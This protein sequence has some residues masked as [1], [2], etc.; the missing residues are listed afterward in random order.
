[1]SWNFRQ[2]LIQKVSSAMKLVIH[3]TVLLSLI[4]CLFAAKDCDAATY[5]VRQTG[6][7]TNTGTSSALAFRTIAKAAATA[8]SGDTVYIGAGIYTERISF[9]GARKGTTGWAEFRGDLA[10][11]Y[12]GDGGRV[13]IRSS[14]SS[15][16]FYAY[17]VSSLLV[18][19]ISFEANPALT[20][21]SYGC[22]VR[23]SAGEVRFES[24]Y[25]SDLVFATRVNSTAA[26]TINACQFDGGKYGIYAT[27]NRQCV[28]SKCLFNAPTYSALF[29]DTVDAQVL[30]CT[31][32][33]VHGV[34]GV[35]AKSRGVHIARSSMT[36]RESSFTGNDIGIYGTD[37]TSVLI[38]DCEIDGATSHAVYC[39]GESLEM[40]DS[41]VHDGNYG[42]TLVDNTGQSVPLSRLVTEK[43]YVGVSARESD[44][45]FDDVTISENQFG[46]HQRSTS[47]LLTLKNTDSI[48]FSNNV[49]AV[50]SNH[51]SGD[52]GELHIDG[53]NF[54]GN[55]AG[56]TCYETTVSIKNSQFEG[57]RYGARLSDCDSIE[58]RGCTF[59]GNPPD[60]SACSYGL[61]VKSNDIQIQDSS[62]RNANYG[63]RVELTGQQAPV[64]KNL[65]S[66]DHAYAALHMRDGTWTYTDEDKN[67]FRN[68]SRGVICAS[69]NWRVEKVTTD[70]SC[71]YPI[72][73]YDGD[74]VIDGATVTAKITGIYASRS[75]SLSVSN[76]TSSNCGTY[77][78]YTYDVG[79]IAIDNFT[80]ANSS[81]GAYLNDS[82][83][84]TFASVT[85]SR[86][87]ANARYGLLLK[88]LTLDPTVA[89]N[90]TVK[91]NQYGISI[92]DRPF[93]INQAMNLTVVGNR[94]GLMSYY[95]DLIIHG[96][97]I[98]GN[99]ISAY[100]YE[101]DV[102]VDGFVS[103]SSS[104]GLIGHPVSKCVIANSE[105]HDAK[106]GISLQPRE[107]V[108][109]PIEI[110]DVAINN[111]AGHAI[112]ARGIDSNTP[113]LNVNGV[114]ITNSHNGIVTDT[115]N[116]KAN[117]IAIDTMTGIGVYQ[118]LGDTTLTNSSISRASSSWSV[119]ARGNRCDVIRCKIT[120]GRYGI[121]FRNKTGSVLNS[122]LHNL[123]YGVYVNESGDYE[124]TQST[125]AGIES[126]GALHYSG[127]TTVRNTIIESDKY[128]FYNAGPGNLD[129]DHNL[130]DAS[131]RAHTNTTPGTGEIN[132]SP[133]FVDPAA[134]N[135]R[136]A[137]GSPA[138]N[139]GAD[140][141]A[142]ITSDMDGNARPSFRAFEIGA[143][144]FQSAA[145]SLR[146]L[147]W[148]EV[149]R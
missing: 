137:A 94:F 117:D 18:T 90:L 3:M 54:R 16:A 81:S 39:Y 100:A 115:V 96:A 106:Y 12:T 136:L 111:S 112:Y 4:L 116:V 45:T 72:M 10:G 122:V 26:C 29:Y 42:V 125:I 120:D 49:Y 20:D 143:Y 121:G 114:K 14:Q 17:N 133:I 60:P 132:K 9:N 78:L 76:S 21:S 127:N 27:D 75:K 11:S 62:S 129:G 97:K 79:S 57:V 58:V 113:T 109:N 144:E 66:E 140:L 15:W 101:S 46:I 59:N 68:A 110:T 50:Y 108:N 40:K 88:G 5:Y 141:S 67:V 69:M 95:S 70:G 124:I 147:D 64:I 8:G 1:M 30:G 77:G 107:T 119:Y 83:G 128:G 82:S 92:H 37:V 104:Y 142:T 63:V 23:E 22:Y 19:G 31:F 56:V 38:D 74:C 24:C 51:I 32:S 73:D 103:S 135:L 134:G 139:A 71:D 47:K 98:S 2:F 118:I 138:I 126:Y 149:A 87:E 43:M 33:S 93:T 91:D 13:V 89:A 41:H 44:Y 7:D 130:I 6:D 145:G 53:Q 105:F 80:A 25:F 131:I 99:E 34:T 35:D 86:F 84:G 55:E 146:V 61:L 85:N 36:V 123:T 102:D 28:I 148:D 65:I 48:K 52:G